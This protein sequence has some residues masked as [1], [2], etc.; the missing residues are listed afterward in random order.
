[1]RDKRS[2]P[3]RRYNRETNIISSIDTSLGVTAIGLDITGVVLS[4]TIVTAPAMNEI[5]AVTI[6]VRIVKVIGNQ[7]KKTFKVEK[8]EKIDICS[9]FQST[10]E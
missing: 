8:H 5:E 1:M 7:A 4:S 6:V 2:E 9:C 10:E 3:G